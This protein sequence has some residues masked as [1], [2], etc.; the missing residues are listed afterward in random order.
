MYLVQ[1]FNKT[2]A[3]TCGFDAALRKP[4]SLHDRLDDW[5]RELKLAAAML[6]GAAVER[7]G[8]MPVDFNQACCSCGG[9][10]SQ[11]YSSQT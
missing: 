1:A 5:T 4:H 8:L 7:L 6:S 9:N 11:L 3:V 10:M 2:A